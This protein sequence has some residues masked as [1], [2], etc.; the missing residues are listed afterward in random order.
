LSQL[1]EIKKFIA[2][3]K[4]Q[5]KQLNFSIPWGGLFIIF[6]ATLSYS[7]M[8]FWQYALCI[9]LLNLIYFF[10]RIQ[11][12][13]KRF[14]ETI[15]FSLS[16]GVIFFLYHS[17]LTGPR[18]LYKLYDAI[19]IGMDEKDI[20][21]IISDYFPPRG[22]FGELTIITE[23]D[24]EKEINFFCF[25]LDPKVEPAEQDNAY[26]YLKEGKV[27]HKDWEPD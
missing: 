16:V 8:M 6:W 1:K 26:I 11:K 27:I 12:V 4:I 9:F 24:K 22:R 23:V 20:R 18:T 5:L 19:E 15:F 10:Y 2:N 17:K 25:R 3:E 13:K 7:L 21:N 14:L